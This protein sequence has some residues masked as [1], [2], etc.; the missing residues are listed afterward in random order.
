MRSINLRDAANVMVAPDATNDAGAMVGFDDGGG[1]RDGSG[2]S[3][4]GGELG[5]TS[6]GGGFGNDGDSEVG[7]GRDYVGVLGGGSFHILV[8]LRVWVVFIGGATTGDGGRFD[9]GC[10]DHD[11]GSG[12]VVVGGMA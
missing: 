11:R 2:G 6:V 10:G 1:A 4:D 5:G 9:G 3:G 7:G 12:V 8:V